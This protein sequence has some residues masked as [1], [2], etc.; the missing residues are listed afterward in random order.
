MEMEPW[1]RGEGRTIGMDC[2]REDTNKI[3]LGRAGSWVIFHGE[4]QLSR[5]GHTIIR[6]T[7]EKTSVGFVD[8]E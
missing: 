7:L 4:S 1:E 2:S 6:E 3:G 8:N 5:C